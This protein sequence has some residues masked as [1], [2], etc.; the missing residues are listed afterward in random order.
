M[1]YTV[2][3]PMEKVPSS[4]C[5]QLCTSTAGCKMFHYDYKSCF[6]LQYPGTGSVNVTTFWGAENWR[7]GCKVM[8]Y[9]VFGGK[10]CLRIVNDKRTWTDAKANCSQDGGQLL[11]MK[12]EDFYLK[13]AVLRESFEET[14]YWIGGNDLV[15]E[16]DWRWNDGSEVEAW[17]W[18][19]DGPSNTYK[20]EHCLEVT[21]AI[22]NDY[23]CNAI[24]KFVCE[25][26]NI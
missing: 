22:F 2:S 16:G 24:R 25:K 17:L 3:L 5:G 9:P 13:H 1:N 18:L 11:T 15:T 7:D 21:A 10:Y 20:N 26:L 19:Q 6:I 8:E 23:N 12:S 4:K 14:P